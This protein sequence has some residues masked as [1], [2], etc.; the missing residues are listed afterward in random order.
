MPPNETIDVNL[1]PTE[2]LTIEFCYVPV[3]CKKF[4]PPKVRGKEDIAP[5]VNV[6]SYVAVLKS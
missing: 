1:P 5:Q 2:L 3:P 4:L 6:S